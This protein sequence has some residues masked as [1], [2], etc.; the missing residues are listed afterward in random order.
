VEHGLHDLARH[1]GWATAQL[2]AYCQRL[3]DATLDTTVPGTF[4]TI[5]ETLQHLVDSEGSY[6][7]RLTRAWPDH[8][9]KGDRAVG[10][11]TLAERS[12]FLATTLEQFL[13][14]QW[15]SEELGEGYG[16]AGE[17]Y[18][19]RSGIFLTQALHHANEHRAHVCTILGALGHE[20]PDV[21]AWGYAGAT[22]RS[23]PKASGE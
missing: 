6:I 22:G 20:P 9:W 11:D 1:N 21:S 10:L 18:A 15:D 17:V 12:A 7:R 3:D 19:I 8:P 23:W 14:G 2:L 5:I 4:G 16:D 13:A